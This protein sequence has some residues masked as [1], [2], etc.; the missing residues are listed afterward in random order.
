MK[1]VAR[2]PRSAPLHNRRP[3]PRRL[4]EHR[5]WVKTLPC[6]RCGRRPPCDP[7]H[8]RFNEG[9]PVY[10]GAMGAQPPD[11]LIVPGCRDC[12]RREENQGKLTFWGEAQAEGIHDPIAVAE[13]LRRISLDTEKGYAA[14]AK[15]RPGLPT[16]RLAG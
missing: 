4:P 6:L 3:D 13:R 5:V 15:A 14:I 9:D 16:A 7:M 8:L 2:I 12:H 10:K 11:W 1:R